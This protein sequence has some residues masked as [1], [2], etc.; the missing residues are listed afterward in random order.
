MNAQQRERVKDLLSRAARLAPGE[1]PAFIERAAEGEVA[2][3]A[4]ELLRTLDD[5]AF[6]SAPTAGGGAPHRE[7]R[8]W[9]PL[10]PIASAPEPRE[11]PGACIGRYKLLEVIGEGGFGTVFMAEQTEPVVRC[12]ALK[13][14]KPGM[15]TRQVIARFEA[16]RQALAMM[17]H[18]GIATVLDG[19]ATDSGRPYFVMELVKGV[20]ITEFC[21]R[22]NMPVPDRLALFR[23]VCGAVQHA[24]QKGVIHRDLKPSNVLVAERDGRPRPKIIDFGIAKATS[25]RL[26]DRTLFTEFR[27]L[28]GTPEYMSPEQ[29]MG[30]GADVDTRTDIYSLGVLLYELLTGTT[31]LDPG[32]LRSADFAEMQRL[33]REAETPRPSTRLSTLGT[34]SDVAA[35]RRI[36]PGRLGLLLRGDLDW[37][38][39]KA[40]EKDRN[41]R[42]ETASALA[43]DVRRFLAHEPVGASPPGAL[44]RVRKFVRRNRGPV[45]AASLVVLMLIVAI[46]GTS[47][48]LFVALGERARAQA[49]RENAERVADFMAE[50]LK[51]V[52]A[53]KA[54]GRDTTVLREMLDAA[55]QRIENGELED[56]PEAELRLRWT[57]GQ[58]YIDIAEGGAAQRAET[59]VRPTL[60]LA[61]GTYG[62]DSA[63]VA[64]S[65]LTLARSLFTLG[66]PDEAR[67]GY[68][69]A[70]ETYQRV[71][72]GDDL[73]IVTTLIDLV[74]CLEALGRPD[75]ALRHA[76][77][78]VAM[79]RR[80]ISGDH[81][82]LASSLNN[83]ATCLHALGRSEEALVNYRASLEM[84]RR[85]FGADHP[86][87]AAC[88][89]NLALCLSSLGRWSEALPAHDAALR[90]HQRLFDGD[91][92]DLAWCLNNIAY[93]LKAM[94]RAA[95]ALP[96]FEAALEMRRRLFDG[97]HPDTA[98]NLNNVA[99]CLD[100]L[101]R[102][103]EAVPRYEAALAMFRR[104]S[105]G[106]QPNLANTMNNLAACL[107]RLGRWAEALPHAEGAVAMNRRMLPP[108]HLHILLSEL[109]RARALAHLS[110]FTE[111]EAV[112]LECAPKLLDR[113]DARESQ[114][115]RALDGLVRLYEAWHIAEPYR[116][117]DQK[118]AEWRERFDAWTAARTATNVG[119]PGGS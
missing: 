37:I 50:L 72:K 105:K 5:P 31:P 55:A 69:Q 83:L 59:M 14:I 75:E 15:D 114:K 90:M 65:Q 113:P 99:A 49:Q 35:H 109:H 2:A 25:G 39:L 79:S 107:N 42:Y 104:S 119:T 6:M 32:S 53:A 110:R 24:H 17:H 86:E 76:D 47:S 3:E 73:T 43:E 88:L 28:V 44:Y 97:D 85:L 60:A 91:H 81:P 21:D 80:L 92:P 118:A 63:E 52:E 116:G 70:L 9:G 18:P 48:G 112:F 64:L 89:N 4:L 11:V 77:A 10:A 51:G 23:E 74:Q 98:T 95:E 84:H 41:R 100:D 26:T 117:H 22:D 87:V 66:R 103:E 108:D 67:L 19:G 33:I 13:V 61:E 94:G 40:L 102:G 7:E 27:Q 93:C 20:P 82:A 34:R 78:S 12:V 8:D 115:Q 101:G 46:A 57:I 68:Q 106:D 45:L 36:E 58:A 16:E 96:Y 1:R 62:A 54:R 30:A 111:A 38:V 71:H 56:S 29:T